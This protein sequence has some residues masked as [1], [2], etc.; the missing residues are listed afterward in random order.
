MNTFL[1]TLKKDIKILRALLIVSTLCHVGVVYVLHFSTDLTLKDQTGYLLWINWIIL[2]FTLVLFIRYNWKFTPV[3]KSK[4]W[5][6]TW[7]M[8]FL[9]ILGMWFW[10]PNEKEMNRWLETKLE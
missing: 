8:I 1:P 3:K 5:E 4:K 2:I 10:L 6:N 9:G 7:M